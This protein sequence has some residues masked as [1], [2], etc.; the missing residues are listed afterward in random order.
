MG[1]EHLLPLP[2][3]RHKGIGQDYSSSQRSTTRPRCP[4]TPCGVPRRCEH[5]Q[6]SRRARPTPAHPPAVAAR[7]QLARNGSWYSRVEKRAEISWLSGCV[8][9]RSHQ[10]MI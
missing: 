1:E 3:S 4:V 9:G 10:A 7:V 6:A 5:T 2:R 8:R